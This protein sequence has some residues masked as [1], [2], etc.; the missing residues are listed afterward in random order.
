MISLFLLIIFCILL[1]YLHMSYHLHCYDDH[2]RNTQRIIT[3]IRSCSRWS[4]ASLQDTSPLVALLHANYGTGY[5]WALQET[6]T[7]YEIQEA[8]HLDIIEYSKKI[9]DIQDKATKRVS[10]ICPQFIK[11]LDIPLLKIAGEA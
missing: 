11:D 1:S 9:T 5:L 6:F 7:D 4:L 2:A 10:M 8:T 3:L